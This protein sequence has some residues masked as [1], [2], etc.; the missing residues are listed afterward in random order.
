[1][2]VADPHQQVRLAIPVDILET[3]RDR[4]QFLSLPEQDGTAVNPGFGRVVRWQLDDQDVAVQVEGE[5]V[6]GVIGRVVVVPDHGVGLKGAR[7]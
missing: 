7:C 2:R 5:K 1:M 3:Q 6:A 4:S